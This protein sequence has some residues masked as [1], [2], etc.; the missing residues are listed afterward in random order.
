[1]SKILTCISKTIK[2]YHTGISHA[3]IHFT[4]VFTNEVLKG[5]LSEI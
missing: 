4:F 5:P 2:L 1:M 3:K